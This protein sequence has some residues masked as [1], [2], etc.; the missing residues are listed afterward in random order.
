MNSETPGTYLYAKPSTLKT[1]MNNGFDMSEWIDY[2][3]EMGYT[4]RLEFGAIAAVNED[5]I[6]VDWARPII[7]THKGVRHYDV[8]FSE[9]N[10]F[11]EINGEHFDTIND[12]INLGLKKISKKARK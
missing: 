1:I 11:F 7:I 6:S 8:I 3:G 2:M 10:S 9:M 4:T 12:D 5:G